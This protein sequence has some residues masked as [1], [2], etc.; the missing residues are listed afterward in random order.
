[1]SQNPIERAQQAHARHLAEKRLVG[2]LMIVAGGVVALLC[3][4]CTLGL[5][6]GTVVQAFQ[7]SSPGPLED[8]VLFA[9]VGGL[10]TAGG[11][12]FFLTGRRIY[13]EGRKKGGEP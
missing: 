5:A 11:V 13:R 12:A 2:G 8:L 3:G 4:M 10:P 6:G 9:L 1:M 7:E